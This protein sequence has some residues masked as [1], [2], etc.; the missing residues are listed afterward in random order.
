MAVIA[1]A[2]AQV[3][4]RLETPPATTSVRSA[5]EVRAEYDRVRGQLVHTYGDWIEASGRE[6]FPDLLEAAWALAAEWAAAYLN[7]HP[8]ANAEDLALAIEQLNL[9]PGCSEH[10]QECFRLDSNAVRLNAGKDASY[11]VSVNFS[12]AGTF[13]VLA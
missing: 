12:R 2:F 3:N 8:D 13:L 6:E 1:L 5:E 10:D 11:A 7:S 4:C 9:L